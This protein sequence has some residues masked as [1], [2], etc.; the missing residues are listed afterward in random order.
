MPPPLTGL[1]FVVDENLLR[2]GKALTALRD[3]LVCFGQPPVVDLLSP[4]IGDTEWIPVVGDHGWVMVTNDRRIR[5]RPSEAY[6]AIEHKLKVVHL[7]GAVGHQTAWAQAVRFLSRWSAIEKQV[8]VSEGPWWLSLQQ[9]S[10]RLLAY[11]PGM[12]ERGN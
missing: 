5:T 8:G 3:D 10:T 6:L 11:E 2:F 4:G 9:K 7:H 1:T 12:P